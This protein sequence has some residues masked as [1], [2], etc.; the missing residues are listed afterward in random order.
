[1]QPLLHEVHCKIN[2]Y[3]KEE[4]RLVKQRKRMAVLR[5]NHTCRSARLQ[6]GCSK[7]VLFPLTFSMSA[8]PSFLH[9][10]S[11]VTHGRPSLKHVPRLLTV[12]C[13]CQFKD[14]WECTR[15]IRLLHICT[16]CDTVWLSFPVVATK[17]CVWFWWSMGQIFTRKIQMVIHHWGLQRVMTSRETCSVSPLGCLKC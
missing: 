4:Q 11:L 10:P 7:P 2:E 13:M 3:E 1:M 14:Y 17:M 5:N 9:C 6:T 16:P 8:L 12:M 15:G